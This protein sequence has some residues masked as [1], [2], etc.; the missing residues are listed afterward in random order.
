MDETITSLKETFSKKQLN[1][2]ILG[3]E[4]SLQK[5]EIKKSLIAHVNE[6][7]LD[8]LIENI[9]TDKLFMIVKDER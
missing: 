7:H 8:L 1:K 6:E 2:L 4:K 9:E 5:A 3:N